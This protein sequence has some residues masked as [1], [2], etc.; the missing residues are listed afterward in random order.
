MDI[1]LNQ[2]IHCYLSNTTNYGRFTSYITH[3]MERVMPIGYCDVT[4]PC[5]Y[6][7]R[8]LSNSNF[9]SHSSQQHME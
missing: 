4:P 7:A 6:A 3:N 9:I 2:L 1:F 5:V 8:S